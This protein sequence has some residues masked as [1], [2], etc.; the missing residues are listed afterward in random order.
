MLIQPVRIARPIRRI[1]LR[2]LALLALAVALPHASS[3]QSRVGRDSSTRTARYPRDIAYG[4]GLG[5]VY[6]GID[7]LRDDPEE[8][9]K[10]WPGYGRRLASNV[11]EFWIQESVTD[12]LAA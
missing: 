7:Q 11:G 2:L 5:F 8:W 6:A 3:A 9:G 12:L 1:R 4:T 10:G